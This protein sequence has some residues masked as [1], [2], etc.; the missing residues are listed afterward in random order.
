MNPTSA[1]EKILKCYDFY[2]DRQ[3]YLQNFKNVEIVHS[4]GYY[5][6]NYPSLSIGKIKKL[7]NIINS[8]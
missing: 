5:I 3:V 6:G 7:V 1:K 4:Y 8:F 2:I